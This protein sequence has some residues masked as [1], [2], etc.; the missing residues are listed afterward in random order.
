MNLNTGHSFNEK[1]KLNIFNMIL[2]AFPFNLFVKNTESRYVITSSVCDKENGVERGALIGKNDYDLQSSRELAE[3]FI[4]D[5]RRII[6]SKKGSRMLTP[7]TC[8]SQITYYDIYKE[9]LIDKFGK[10]YGVLGLVMNLEDSRRSMS[11]ER[12]KGNIENGKS[13]GICIMFD[14]D[15]DTGYAYVFRN[16]SE[17]RLKITSDRTFREQIMEV[18]DEESS[19]AFSN[20]F[21]DFQENHK[22][23]TFLFDS[24]DE[25]N[26]KHSYILSLEKIIGSKLS[27]IHA[28]GTVSRL[29]DETKITD[30]LNLSIEAMNENMIR[31]LTYKY[32]SIFYLNGRNSMYRCI[33]SPVRHFKPEG[34]IEDF[35]KEAEKQICEEDLEIFRDTVIKSTENY[36]TA[37]IRM[38]KGGSFRWKKLDIYRFKGIDGISTDTVI[39]SID[40]NELVMLRKYNETRIANNQ[41]I[42]ILTSVVES[43]NLESGNHI[44]RIRTVTRLLLEQ[45]MVD[46]PEYE[47]TLELIDIISSASALHDIGKIAIPDSILLKPGKLTDEE[48]EIMKGHTIKGCEIIN[49]AAAIQDQEY[50]KY[51]YDICRHHHE[52]YDGSGYPDG[53][54]GDNIS[55]AAQTVSLADV[56]DALISRRCYKEAFDEEKVFT[57]ITQG[58]S[59]IFNPKL[60]KAMNRIRPELKSSYLSIQPK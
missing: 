13:D 35:F 43:R 8:G 15:L 55:L 21:K 56:Y 12:I 28:F 50:Y 20:A 6:Q 14:F 60:L 22:S 9:P 5:D 1:Q 10:V 26:D 59:G 2:E 27:R 40:M 47:L 34:M 33:S 39:T 3:I 18:M 57:M 41:L 25:E 42:D 24:F 38:R 11:L 17:I 45:I 37:D 19:V 32:D 48:F 54:R 53:L 23:M 31:M 46:F 16:T 51:C 58:E 49:S 4:N 36:I 29:R 52:R 30:E 44:Q 7:V